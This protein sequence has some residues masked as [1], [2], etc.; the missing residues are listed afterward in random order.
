[1]KLLLHICCGP[2]TTYPLSV[3]REEGIE[4]VGV[5]FNP[6][7]HPVDEFKRRRENVEKLAQI[8]GLKVNYFDDFRQPDWE[9]FKGEDLARCTMCYTVRLEK[10]A[11]LAAEGGFDAFTTTLLVS[12]YQKHELIKELGEK[13]ARQYGT[14]FYYRDFRPGFRQGQKEA[15]DLGLYRQKY[16]GC[17]ISLSQR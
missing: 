16:C 11:K 9:N 12:P 3:L 8:K 17:I 5:F 14:R 4:P 13:F 2:C 7:I 1:M 15:K 10:A 6:N